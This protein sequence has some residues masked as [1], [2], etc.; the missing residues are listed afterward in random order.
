MRPFRRA[1]LDTDRYFSVYGATAGL[2]VYCALLAIL[3][4]DIGFDGDDWW[5]LSRPFWYDFPNSFFVYARE[6]LRPVEGLYWIG[7]FE[8]FGFNSVAFHLGS[9]LL[10]AGA[11]FLQGLCL[12]K[13]FPGSP[14]FVVFCMFFA[15]FLPMVSALTYLVFTDNAR[16]SLLLFWASVLMFQ[17]WAERSGSWWGQIP[18]VLLYLLSFLTYEGPSFLIF[19]VPL[20]V[21]PVYRISTKAIPEKKFLFRVLVG[22]SVGFALAVALRFSLLAGGA[23]DRHGSFPSPELLWAYPALLPSYLAA[24]FTTHASDPWALC[25]G[26]FVALWIVVLFSLL[27]RDNGQTDN[28]DSGSEP[29]GHQST[30]Y[31]VLLGLLILVLGMLPYQ[32]AGYGSLSP[33][34][35][36]TVLAKWG[37]A[38]H[39][40]DAWFNFN[41]A[42]RIYSSASC[43]LAIVFAAVVCGFRKKLPRL[44]VTAVA[45]V[46]V[47][48]M[49]VFHAGLS[50]DWKE[51]AQIRNALIGSL[52]VQ[53]PAVEP[54]TNFLLLDLESYHK[55]AA[56]FRGWA[57]LRELFK[58]LYDDRSVGAWYL[59]S[60]ATDWP[61]TTQ[62]QAIV[63]PAGILSRSM[64]FDAP[65]AHNS[66]LL[67]KREGTDL[68]LLEKIFPGD[69][70]VTTGITWRQY[71]SIV[72]NPGRIRIW[73]EVAE[74]TPHAPAKNSRKTGLLTTLGLDRPKS[75][76]GDSNQKR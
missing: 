61:N 26:A 35:A 9:V 19:A 22:I 24:P 23:I 47:G 59:H 11:A 3:T 53:V 64:S 66:L 6:F 28:L 55:R 27:S 56:V 45:T 10:L 15:F 4:G 33:S 72:S 62:Q 76:R 75:S 16:L 30:L 40:G 63:L 7:M 18:A 32:L 50:V 31:R 14:R 49:A 48:F 17:S 39:H 34:V 43:G 21:W 29:P 54:G 58:M 57:G 42:S 2:I 12:S 67:F 36:E 41:E 71:Q 52:L 37:I 46:S 69:G 60:S 70:L 51:A 13:A 20:L 25:L 8:F 1:D 68:V 74:T 5:V 65:A 73:S 38:S 44:I